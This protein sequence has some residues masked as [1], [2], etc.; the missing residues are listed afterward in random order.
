MKRVFICLSILCLP[1]A[2]TAGDATGAE[3]EVRAASADF[4][5]AYETNDIGR[6]FGYYAE[7]AVVWWFGERQDMAAYRKEWEAL[8]EAGGGVEENDVSDEIFQVLPGGKAVIASYFVHN[9]TR[10]ADGEKTTAKA[11]ESEVWVKNDGKWK[12]VSLHYSEF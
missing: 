5:D 8:I 9:V 7:D 11:Y 12:V 3:D 10:S 1:L 4:N 2:V 6:Y